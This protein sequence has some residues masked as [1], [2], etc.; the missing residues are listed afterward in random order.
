MCIY[1]KENRI[2]ELEFKDRLKAM[3]K[4]TGLSQHKFGRLF[5]IPVINMSNWEQGLSKPPSYTQAMIE[6]LFEIDPELQQYKLE[7]Q[8]VEDETT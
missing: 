3:R 1:M 7:N 6:R 8:I 5:N 2:M 4:Q